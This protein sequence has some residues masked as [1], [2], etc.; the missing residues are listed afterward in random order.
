MGNLIGK[1][2]KDI[3]GTNTFNVGFNN[4]SPV[5]GISRQASPLNV[6]T[7]SASFSGPGSATNTYGALMSSHYGSPVIPDNAEMG[8]VYAKAIGQVGKMSGQLGAAFMEAE[9]RGWAPNTRKSSKKSVSRK[10]SSPLN[11]DDSETSTALSSDVS[12]KID[13]Q[14]YGTGGT[15]DALSGE[16][17]EDDLKVDED[18][19]DQ[20]KLLEFCTKN[21]N[22]SICK[23]RNTK[24]AFSDMN[25]V[26]R[27]N[28]LE[29]W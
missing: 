2:K 7:S 10:S 28:D 25:A 23:G 24:T 5:K 14:D 29:W 26:D 16:P 17:S 12:A 6:Y 20:D 13:E 22:H 9:E 27:V 21:P 3:L 19:T 15:D 4:K 11:Q 1:I 18:L 8:D